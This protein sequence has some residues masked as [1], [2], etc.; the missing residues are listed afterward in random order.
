MLPTLDKAAAKTL[1][2]A[3]RSVA[4]NEEAIEELLGEEAWSTAL[5]DVPVHEPRSDT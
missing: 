3:L 2:D 5:E 1:G 4:Y